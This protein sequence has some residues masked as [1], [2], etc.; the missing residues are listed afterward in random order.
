MSGLRV[1][2]VVEVVAATHPT[3]LYTTTCVTHVQFCLHTHS[4]VTHR[5]KNNSC[6]LDNS[7]TLSTGKIP[8]Y[9]TQHSTRPWKVCNKVTIQIILTKLYNPSSPFIQLFQQIE[10]IYSLFNKFK[11]LQQFKIKCQTST[12]MCCIVLNLKVSEPC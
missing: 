4:L 1:V 5:T 10:Q 11:S 12:L 8:H 9:I 3:T 6:V 2:V 7:I